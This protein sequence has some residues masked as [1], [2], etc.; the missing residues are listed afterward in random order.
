MAK[1]QNF[2]RPRQNSPWSAIDRT[3]DY[4]NVQAHN[5]SREFIDASQLNPHNQLPVTTKHENTK[6]LSSQI[7][8]NERLLYEWFSKLCSCV[9]VRDSLTL[10]FLIP[11]PTV[12]TPA[13]YKSKNMAARFTIKTHILCTIICLLTRNRC[14]LCFWQHAW[15]P[16][17]TYS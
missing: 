7:H 16:Y 2:F 8:K 9:D 13:V 4:G 6:E 11:H 1:T 5:G 17:R 12:F 10:T 3:M 15:Q 14:L